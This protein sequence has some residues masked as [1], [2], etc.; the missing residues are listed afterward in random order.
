ML[1]PVAEF[2]PLDDFGQAVLAIEFAPFLLGRL[3]Q[4]MRHR[5]RRL[6]AEAAFCLGGSM[7]DGSKGAD[8]RVRDPDVLPM[9]G[10]KIIVRQQIGAVLGQAFDRRRVFHAVS[11]DE[12]IEGSVGLGLGFR[13]RPRNSEGV[14]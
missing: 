8:H 6:A 9:L 2:N 5:Q 7:P 3:H 14:D 11:L 12:D 13:P 4:L 10:W 1:D